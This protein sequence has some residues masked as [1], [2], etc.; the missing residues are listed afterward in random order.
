GGAARTFPTAS[1]EM[2]V[3]VYLRGRRKNVRNSF[4][5]IRSWKPERILIAHGPQPTGDT[6]L[7]LKRGFSW[8]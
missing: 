7:L 1:L 2:R 3:P 8:V 6:D 5:T 4:D